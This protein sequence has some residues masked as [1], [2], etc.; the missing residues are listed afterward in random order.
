M[1]NTIS[2]DVTET[3]DASDCRC[4]E[5]VTAFGCPWFWPGVFFGLGHKF[6]PWSLSRALLCLIPWPWP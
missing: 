6:L 4:G 1:F 2:F 3:R 5:L